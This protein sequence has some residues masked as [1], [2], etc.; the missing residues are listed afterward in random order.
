MNGQN[1]TITLALGLLQKNEVQAQ[2]YCWILES[3]KKFV[4]GDEQLPEEIV[5]VIDRELAFYNALLVTF[6]DSVFIIFCKW[7]LFRAVEAHLK[8]AFKI[9]IEEW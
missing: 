6:Q 1:K 7:H 5:W 8:K 2:D 4:W 3:Y 9:K